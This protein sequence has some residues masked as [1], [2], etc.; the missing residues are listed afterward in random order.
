AAIAV[1][2]GFGEEILFRGALQPLA[3]Y[4]TSP[5]VGIVAVSL[6]FGAAHAATPTYFFF[7]T[8]VSL[9]LG[10]LAYWSGEILSAGIAHALYDFLAIE[11]LLRRSRR[12][13][14]TSL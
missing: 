10:S 11:Y 6:L 2:T 1:A 14:L 7:A 9:Y 12:A 13:S 3:I 8:L 4:W 5:L